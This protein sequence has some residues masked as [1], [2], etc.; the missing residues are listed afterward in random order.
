MSQVGLV[1]VGVVA[2]AVAVAAAAVVVVLQS[3]KKIFT[4]YIVYFLT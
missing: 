4:K 1:E 2:P 3:N